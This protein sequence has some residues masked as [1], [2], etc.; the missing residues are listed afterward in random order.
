MRGAQ[1]MI[2]RILVIGFVLAVILSALTGCATAP[3]VK[4]QKVYVKGHN[5]CRIAKKIR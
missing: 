5:Y 3:P 1:E 4:V 2:P